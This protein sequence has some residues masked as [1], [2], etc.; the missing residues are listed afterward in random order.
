MK[1]LPGDFLH[2]ADGKLEMSGYW[3]PARIGTVNLLHTVGCCQT[4]DT[5]FGMLSR[6][7]VRQPVYCRR[8]CERG[9]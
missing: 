9:S 3:N 5:F 4:S 2:L 1:L 7:K 6:N 8:A